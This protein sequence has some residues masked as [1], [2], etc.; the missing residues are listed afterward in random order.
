M[1]MTAWA[2]KVSS[3]LI[4]FSVNGRTSMRRIRIA[5][6]GIPSRSKGVAAPSEHRD[7]WRS[8]LEIVLWLCCQVM[9]MKGSPVNHGSA[10]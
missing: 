4:C 5:P 1:A 9:N 10:G 7:F 8:V 2:A 3:S 6:M